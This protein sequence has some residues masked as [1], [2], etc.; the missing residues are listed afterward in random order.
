M[1]V[2]VV[3]IDGL[4]SDARSAEII[5]QVKDTLP[6]K[7]IRYVISTH[8]HF[9]HAA[10]LRAFVAEGATPITH[11]VNEDFFL[12]ALSSP[13]TLANAAA[14][15][16]P[17]SGLGVGDFFSLSDTA[18]QIHL[19]KLEGSPHADDMLIAWLPAINA[20]VEA[21]LLQPW[22][23]PVFSGDGDGPHPS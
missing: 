20:V 1:E 8:N 19:Y 5:A 2:G 10:G 16:V 21:D 7:N 3:V 22:I 23:N 17:V 18:V 13:R 14:Q 15:D 12:E 4:Q 9:D 6:G 11:K